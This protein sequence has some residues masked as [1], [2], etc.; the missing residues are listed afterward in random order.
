LDRYTSFNT[1]NF[2]I[3]GDVYVVSFRL[4]QI[5]QLDTIKFDSSNKTHI[6]KLAL[7]VAALGVSAISAVPSPEKTSDDFDEVAVLSYDLRTAI[8]RMVI[9]G[10][11]ASSVHLR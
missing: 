8:D 10:H 1:S 7:L 11:D 5:T 4:D 9:L 2:V 6:T 3:K